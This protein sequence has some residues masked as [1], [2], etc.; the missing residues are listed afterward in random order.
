METPP[1]TVEQRHSNMV[2]AR[3]WAK[4]DRRGP[5]D[6]WEWLGGRGSTD[7]TYGR[8]SISHNVTRPA[9][10][11]AWEIRNGRPFPEGKVACHSCDNPICVNP[12]HIWPGSQAENLLDC[13]MKGRTNNPPKTHCSRGHSLTPE[14]RIKV[15]RGTR[16][17]TCQR[18]HAREW[19]RKARQEKRNG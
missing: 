6:C 10:Q 4:V 8:A 12:A 15:P 7:N 18:E 5:D 9:H 14:N 2:Q 13:R 16:C 1:P 3:F 11:V 17:R 19:V